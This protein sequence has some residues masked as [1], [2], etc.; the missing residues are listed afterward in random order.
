MCAVRNFYAGDGA[1]CR[2]SISEQHPLDFQGFRI[3]SNS[4][5]LR[6]PRRNFT[7]FLVRGIR[8]N[9]RPARN[10]RRSC[11]MRLLFFRI[12]CPDI[13]PL[14]GLTSGASTEINDR[15]IRSGVA[16]RTPRVP[17]HYRVSIFFVSLFLFKP[18]LFSRLDIFPPGG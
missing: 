2:G 18:G 13:V 7:P 1:V 15:F 10:I 9:S 14:L 12:P 16:P 5:S 17:T 4:A 6:H 3:D 8:V 11:A